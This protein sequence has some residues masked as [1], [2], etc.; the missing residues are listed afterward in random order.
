MTRMFKNKL[1]GFTTYMFQASIG[2]VKNETALLPSTPLFMLSAFLRAN[3]FLPFLC[4]LSIL[5]SFYISGIIMAK[6]L[7]APKESQKPEA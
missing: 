3:D 2:I 1:K 4:F 6:A 5:N 7:T